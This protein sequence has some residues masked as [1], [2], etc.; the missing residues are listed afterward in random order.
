M[1]PRDCSRIPSDLIHMD[2]VYP[3]ICVI[4]R[5]GNLTY[6]LHGRSFF[7]ALKLTYVSN[8]K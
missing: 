8:V 3:L 2:N 1:T 5:Q 6:H 4:N 7:L